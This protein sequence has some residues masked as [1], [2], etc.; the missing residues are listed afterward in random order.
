MPRNATK[1]TSIRKNTRS[2]RKK[3][4]RVLRKRAKRVPKSSGQRDYLPLIL[5]GIGLGLMSFW[6]LHKVVYYRSLRLSRDIVAQVEQSQELPLPTHIFIPWNTDAD[7]E[8][9][10][11]VDG[12]WQI[13][14]TKVTYLVGSA[15]PGEQ[16]NIIIYGHNRRE[17]LGNI[18]VLKGGEK[19][20]ITTADGKQHLYKVTKA[21]EVEPSKVELLAPSETQILTMYTCSGFW[22]SLRYIVQ[23]TPVTGE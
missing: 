6:L 7:I 20:T 2:T 22:D 16:G 15:R 13:S 18:R 12:N 14:D 3:V 21:V 19:V 10:A 23:A 17:I 9:L 11:F 1:K 5:M 8:P 4:G